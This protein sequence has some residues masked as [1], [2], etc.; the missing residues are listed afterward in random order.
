M[1]SDWKPIYLR[2]VRAPLADLAF[3][4]RGLAIAAPV[5]GAWHAGCSVS[6]SSCDGFESRRLERRFPFPP[7]DAAEGDAG[8]PN[9]KECETFCNQN[10]AWGGDVSCRIESDDGAHLIVC[11]FNT[12]CEG[13]RPSGFVPP[14]IDPHAPLLGRYFAA[15]AAAEAA[16][17]IAFER[18][19]DE[20][21]SHT[22]PLS[23]I[24]AARRAA[25]D[26]GRHW[27][28][29]SALARRF[30]AR[31]RPGAV[32]RAK[33]RTLFAIGIENAREGVVRE[34]LGAAF[35]EWQARRASEPRVRSV[36]RRIAR[37]ELSHAMLSW[38]LDAWVRERLPGKGRAELDDATSAAL[39]SMSLALAAPVHSELVTRAGLPPPRVTQAMLEVARAELYG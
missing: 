12:L 10:G 1:E 3:L 6:S 33:P 18:M 13:R 34:T 30:G 17:V 31:A 7:A 27:R 15:M 4:I 20:L 2:C 28:M 35:A 21:A 14:M 39:A 38:E 36:M 25:A 11:A 5:L 16:S 9:D 32:A 37:D 26:E 29:T 22:A 8:P 23:L 19:A 24:R